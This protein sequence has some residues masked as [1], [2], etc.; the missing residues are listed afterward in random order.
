VATNI[1]GT[2]NV[3]DAAKR[4]GV[5]RFINFQTALCY[6]APSQLPIPE[7]HPCRPVSSYAISKL[8]GEQYVA[9]SGLGYV[10]IRLASVI[11]PRL[12]IGAIPTFYSRLKAGKAVFCTTAVRDYLDIE[13]FLSIMEKVLESDRSGIFNVGPGIGHSI[14]DVLRAVAKGM[15][16]AVP[17]PLDVRPTAADDVEAVVLDAGE[18]QRAFAWTPR[19]SLQDSI[20]R[21]VRWYDAHGVSAI[22]SHL[23][24]EPQDRAGAR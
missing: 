23:H 7:T 3:V 21:M 19:V 16:V 13:D 12:T 14:S 18:A 10:S 11:A 20:A 4:H 24:Q 22:Y 9:L 15:G 8:A 2:I 5:R 1:S 17:E 6:G